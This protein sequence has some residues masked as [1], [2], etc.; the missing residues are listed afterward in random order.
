L[1]AVRKFSAGWKVEKGE[2]TLGLGGKISY[3]AA[4]NG[5]HNRIQNV[6][7]GRTHAALFRSSRGR[8]SK[9]VREER[10]GG[11]RK[12]S[13]PKGGKGKSLRRGGA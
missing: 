12:D 5:R 8:E 10:G 3:G 4:V 6:E 11:K 2:P 9:E 13:I 1:S 7:Q